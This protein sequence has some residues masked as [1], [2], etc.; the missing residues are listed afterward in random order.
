MHI[1]SQGQVLLEPSQFWGAHGWGE[2]ASQ[3]RLAL[4]MERLD[5]RVHC[6]L[7]YLLSLPWESRE[8]LEKQK[9]RVVLSRTEGSNYSSV[10]QEHVFKLFLQNQDQVRL[11]EFGFQHCPILVWV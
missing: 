11:V 9:A 6:S 5:R 8:W 1:R 10:R 2:A 4:R 7:L 3:E